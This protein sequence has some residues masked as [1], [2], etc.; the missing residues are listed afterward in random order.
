MCYSCPKDFEHEIGGY[1]NQLYNLILGNSIKRIEYGICHNC[2]NLSLVTIKALE[3]PEFTRYFNAIGEP[4]KG[5]NLE[6]LKIYVPSGSL[7]AYK[8]AE[9]WKE[10]AD[11]IF[12]ENK[13]EDKQK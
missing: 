7:D 11:N 13:K 1:N 9:G 8:K 2:K 5:C 10:Y 4:F 6:S 3:P 12:A